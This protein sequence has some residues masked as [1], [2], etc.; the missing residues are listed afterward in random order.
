[1]AQVEQDNHEQGGFGS[2]TVALFEHPRLPECLEFV[3]TGRHVTRRC[4]VEDGLSTTGGPVF[5]GGDHPV[6]RRAVR[7]SRKLFET[8]AR[9]PGIPNADGV[10]TT[11]LWDDQERMVLRTITS[12]LAPL[13]RGDVQKALWHIRSARPKRMQLSS[14]GKMPEA[15]GDAWQIE[16]PTLAWYFRSDPYLHTWIELR[17][18]T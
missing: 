1:M 7:S 8:L 9:D 5:F 4:C 12:V 13:R 6:Y 17:D 10:A 15:T 16:G 14:F 2:C 18:G 11:E 3:L